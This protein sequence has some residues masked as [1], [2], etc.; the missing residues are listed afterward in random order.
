MNDRRDNPKIDYV[1][2]LY[3][4]FHRNNIQFIDNYNKRRKFF[5]SDEDHKTELRFS[6]GNG[7]YCHFAYMIREDQYLLKI[8]IHEETKYIE[9][10][11]DTHRE[12]LDEM[13]VYM[14]KSKFILGLH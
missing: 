2:K 9:R 6:F 5:I 7:N 12:L 8:F 1:H 11:S 3:D 10:K 4:E 13:L 14:R